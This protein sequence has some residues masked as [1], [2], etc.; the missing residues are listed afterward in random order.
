MRRLIWLAF[1]LAC[2]VVPFGAYVRLSDAGLGAR[3][4]RDVTARFLRTTPP[5]KSCS[6]THRTLTDRSAWARPGG[7]WGIATWPARWV[8]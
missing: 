1:I 7:K 4:G 6:S 3:T 5:P 8:C 2:V